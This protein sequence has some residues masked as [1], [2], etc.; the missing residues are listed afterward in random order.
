MEHLRPLTGHAAIP[1]STAEAGEVEAVVAA[2]AI[3]AG[4]M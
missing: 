2:E 3:A 1:A 4:D